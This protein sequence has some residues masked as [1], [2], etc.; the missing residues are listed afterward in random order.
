MIIGITG[1]LGAGKG[2]VVEFLKQK[3]FAHFSVRDFLTQEL[4]KRNLLVNRDNLLFIANKLREENSPGYIVER[5]YEKARNGT[6][7]GVIESLRSVGEVEVLKNKGAFHLIAIDADIKKR[8][9]RVKQRKSSTDN[10]TFEKFA[11]DEKI[12]TTSEDPTKSNLL[13]CIELADF[14]IENNGDLNDLKNEVDKI[15]AEIKNRS[16]RPSWDEYFMEIAKTVALRATCNRGK[17]GCVITKD[18]RILVTGYVGSPTGILHCD[19]VGHQMKTMVHEDGTKTQHCVRTTHAEQ[20]AIC[21]AAKLGVSI[22]GATVYCKMTPCST[23]AKLIINSG[24]KRVVAEKRYHAE[25]ESEELFNKAGIKLEILDERV[26]IYD[27]Q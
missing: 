16:P 23:C 24:I 17:S 3:G 20:N 26:E 1:T 2:T 14:R 13:K 21:Q 6:K 19:E 15:Y 27:Y 18:K 4:E 11:E 10:I 5:L 12:E 9:E 8:Y 25:K 7:D 22:D